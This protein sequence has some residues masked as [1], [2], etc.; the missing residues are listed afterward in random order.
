MLERAYYHG[1]CYLVE[2][3]REPFVVF[4]SVEEYRRLV[5]RAGSRKGA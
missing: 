3:S 5:E 2:R 4:L 1:Q